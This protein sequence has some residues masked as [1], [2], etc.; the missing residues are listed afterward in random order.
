MEIA[1]VLF[2]DIVGYSKLLT[3]QQRERLQELN[4][5][6]RETE[7][8]RAAEANDKLVRIPTGDGWCSPFL[9]ARTLPRA[10]RSRSIARCES[11]AISPCAWAST[12]A[13]STWSRM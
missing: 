9:P 12:A 2:I 3:N 6:V 11:G 1:H 7:Q 13:R 8:F 5:V 4:R 10:V